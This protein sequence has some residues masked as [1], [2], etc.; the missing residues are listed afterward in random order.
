MKNVGNIIEHVT[1][2]LSARQRE[3]VEERFGLRDNQE[4][5]LQE[6]G[7]RNG[8]TRERVR[9]IEAEGLRLARE[10]F[11]DSDGDQLV[12][13]AKAHLT[14]LGGIR[15]ENDFV[16]DMQTILKDDSVN[17]CQLRFLFK[18]AGEPMHYNEDDSF[19]SFWCLDKAIIKK[20]ETFIEKAVKFFGGK[21]EELV[22]KG[23]FDPHFK[24]LATASNV[25]LVAGMDYLSISK[26]FA[27]NPYSD[28]GLSH[29][30]EITPKTA[31]AKA[32]LILRKH[33]KPMHFRDIAG[34]INTTGFDK[35]PVYAQ[36]IH[37]E[38]IKDNRF[39]LVGRGMYGLTEHGFFPGTAKDVI[40]QV[41]IDNGPLAQQNVVQMVSSQRFLKENTI[42]LNLQNK[43]HFKRLEDGTYHVA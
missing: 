32:Y 22:F 8:I 10:H 4:K 19:Y 42:L 17:Q 2:T 40:R 26:K 33:G 27:T 39:V 16:K 41:L 6:L 36:T 1:H 12:A 11:K 29:W 18:I 15:K 37:N 34:T 9:Q 21:K 35:K 30:E 13:I 3:I 25:D 28:F 23:Q 7:E 14:S 43:K 20:A 31:R 24:Q 38:L 5:T